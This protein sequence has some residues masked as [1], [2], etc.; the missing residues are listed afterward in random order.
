MSFKKILSLCAATSVIAANAL[1]YDATAKITMEGFILEETQEKDSNGVYEFFKLNPMSVGEKNGIEIGFDGGIAGGSFKLTYAIDGAS[2]AEDGWD[3]SAKGTNIWFKPIDQLKLKFGYVG[4]N[5]FLC[6]RE[7]N[8]KVGNPFALNHRKANASDENVKPLYVTNADVDEMGFYVGVSPIENLILSAAIAPGIGNSGLVLDSEK[9]YAPWGV[10]AEYIWNDFIFEAAFRDN[11]SKK[12]KQVRLGAGY[13]TENLF[14]FVQPVFALEYYKKSNSYMFSGICAD[15]YGEY[16]LFDVLKLS[17]HLPVT[18]RLT[19]SEKDPSYF[20]YFIKAAYNFGEK[21]LIDDVTVYAQVE[22][23]DAVTLDSLMSDSITLETKVG[24]SFK[25]GYCCTDLGLS[26]Q[27]HSE[28]ES[29]EKV[30]FAI[31][32][33]VKIEM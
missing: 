12:W 8:A 29:S 30:T 26:V 19:G 17:A 18:F 28:N 4:T 3:V 31:P 13:E 20:E 10:T 6:E 9:S 15:L 33:S 32:F 22:S 23:L 11:G 5:N 2:K 25:V 1:A 7:Y 16:T 24:T 14:A 21:G 27:I